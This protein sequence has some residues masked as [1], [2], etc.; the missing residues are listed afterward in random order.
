VELDQVEHMQK[1]RARRTRDKQRRLDNIEH[2]KAQQAAQEQV[3]EETR[4]IW[5]KWRHEVEDDV[6]KWKTEQEQTRRDKI[7]VRKEFNEGCKRQLEEG[8]AKRIAQRDA[9]GCRV[10]GPALGPGER[11]PT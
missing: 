6:E 3:K 8:R 10:G 2:L 7:E 4:E 5:K 9:L 1:E 11:G